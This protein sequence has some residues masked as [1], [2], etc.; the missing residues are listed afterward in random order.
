MEIREEIINMINNVTDQ[1]ILL[2]I[3]KLLIK[4]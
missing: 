1:H 2:L 3:Y 4:L